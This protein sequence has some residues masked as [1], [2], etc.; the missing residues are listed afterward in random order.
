MSS[1]STSP[2]ISDLQQDLMDK[3]P[4]VQ[5]RIGAHLISVVVRFAMSVLILRDAWDSLL[6]T[7]FTFLTQNN[8]A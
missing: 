2:L 3:L 7:P 4:K 6:A 8:Y 1:D 5:R